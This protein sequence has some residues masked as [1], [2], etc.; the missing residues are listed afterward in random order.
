MCATIDLEACGVY[1]FWMKHKNRKIIRPFHDLAGMQ[2]HCE[3]NYLLLCHILPTDSWKEQQLTTTLG[4]SV[5][6]Y[7]LQQTAYTMTIRMQV[8]SIKNDPVSEETN[9]IIRLYH[10]ASIAEV[11]ADEKGRQLSS[12][13]PYPNAAMH[14]PDEKYR[15]N[16]HLGEWLLNCYKKATNE[17][18][19]QK[20]NV[21]NLMDK[22]KSR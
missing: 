20:L 17:E 13:Y 2:S 6:F 16:E 3:A 14:H 7:F 9:W 4:Q 19:S 12:R 10:D 22:V 21:C 18:N 5:T 1:S 15:L 8:S 11:L